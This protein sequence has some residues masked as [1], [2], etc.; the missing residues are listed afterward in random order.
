M[1]SLTDYKIIKDGKLIAEG[2]AKDCYEKLGMTKGQFANMTKHDEWHGMQV[3][4]V[5]H[6]K[7]SAYCD[8]E[9]LYCKYPDC[10]LP[11]NITPSLEIDYSEMVDGIRQGGNYKHDNRTASNNN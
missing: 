8:L 9:C 5:R 3:E 7:E 11:S 1:K 2:S 4:K 6:K 10:I